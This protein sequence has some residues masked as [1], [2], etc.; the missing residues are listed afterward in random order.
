MFCLGGPPRGQFR[1]RGLL[2][3]GGQ[4]S[5]P[6]APSLL[7]GCGSIL[8]RR[9]VGV[10]PALCCSFRARVPSSIFSWRGP[11]AP[12]VACGLNSLLPRP[13]TQAPG[14]CREGKD[15]RHGDSRPTWASEGLT[16]PGWP[17]GHLPR[18]AEP[19]WGRRTRQR[20]ACGPVPAHARP[21]GPRRPVGGGQG[22]PRPQPLKRGS[23]ASP[24][25]TPC[26]RGFPDPPAKLGLGLTG[27]W[28]RLRDGC[29]LFMKKRS[30]G[31]RWSKQE[32]RV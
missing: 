5:R 18:L 6:R 7:C 8:R 16:G 26:P 2:A 14:H 11:R 10:S 13:V 27:T 1:P 25:P 15:K 31:S 19:G 12:G 28:C 3:C 4:G 17:C 23:G 24:V 21:R 29:L 30:P 20:S 32:H 22:L 9:H